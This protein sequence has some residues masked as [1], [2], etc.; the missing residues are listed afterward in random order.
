VTVE[1]VQTFLRSGKNTFVQS[2]KRHRLENPGKVTLEVVLVMLSMGMVAPILPL[3]G[4][5]FGASTTLVGYVPKVSKAASARKMSR[6]LNIF[7]SAVHRF[8]K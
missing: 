2:G 5:T 8:L 1:G 7:S 4:K 6:R 3:Y